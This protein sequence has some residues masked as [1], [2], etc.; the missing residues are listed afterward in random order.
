MSEGASEGARA[1]YAVDLSEEERKRVEEALKQ[2]KLVFI[3]RRS[4][5]RVSIEPR[6][7]VVVMVR[8]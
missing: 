8:D 1:V 4:D 5:V 7:R 3:T 6:D 2:G